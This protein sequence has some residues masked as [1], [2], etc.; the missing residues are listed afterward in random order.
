MHQHGVKREIQMTPAQQL[1][2]AIIAV[3]KKR[4]EGCEDCGGKGHGDKMTC[5]FPN[6][7][8]FTDCQVCKDCPPCPTCSPDRAM[9]EGMC[10]HEWGGIY[11]KN[12]EIPYEK[13]YIKCSKCNR[14]FGPNAYGTISMMRRS[15]NPTYSTVESIRVELEKLDLWEGKDGF[16]EWHVWQ[17]CSIYEGKYT[18]FGGYLLGG[19]ASADIL[20]NPELLIQAV[21]SYLE[22]K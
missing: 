16:V 18:S 17:T 4:V 2:N 9:L 12:G 5:T 14:E 13:S 6:K 21:M 7:A 19:K 15:L 8:E 11:Q 20:T 10:W 22:S 1:H 3:L